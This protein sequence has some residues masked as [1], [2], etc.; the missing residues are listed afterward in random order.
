MWVAHHVFRCA[1]INLVVAT[2]VVAVYIGKRLTELR[3]LRQ[4]IFTR[5]MSLRDKFAVRVC[6]HSMTHVVSLDSHR[7]HACRSHTT[8]SGLF[9]RV[10][11]SATV[12]VFAEGIAR[13]P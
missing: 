8:C 5:E 1:D 2:Y 9:S 11:I 4:S 7:V 12:D 6:S 3:C 10:G 13:R